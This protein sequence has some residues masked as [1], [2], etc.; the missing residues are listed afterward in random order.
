M[1]VSFHLSYKRAY[2]LGKKRDRSFVPIC[3]SIISWLALFWENRGVRP[4]SLHAIYDWFKVLVLLFLPVLCRRCTCNRKE[5][6]NVI[7]VSPPCAAFSNNDEYEERTKEER[8]KR[9]R[10]EHK[11]CSTCE[12]TNSGFG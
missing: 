10:R 3:R 5:H 2:S 7:A 1:E 12:G 4:L 6:G 9:K 11:K 8:N